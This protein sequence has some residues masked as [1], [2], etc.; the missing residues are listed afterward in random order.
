MHPYITAAIAEQRIA[1]MRSA[2]AARRRVKA[3]QAAGTRQ[4]RSRGGWPLAGRRYRQVELR[5]PDGVCT[6]VPAQE[7]PA[8]A[9]QQHQRLTGTRR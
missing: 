2:A 7:A 1:D 5:W 9:Q 4:R 8:P 6:V 3:A